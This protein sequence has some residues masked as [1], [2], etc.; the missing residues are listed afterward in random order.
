MLKTFKFKQII[1]RV[2]TSERKE[3]KAGAGIQ[4]FNT[5]SWKIDTTASQMTIGKK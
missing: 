3:L 4:G 2:L 1:L 5:S